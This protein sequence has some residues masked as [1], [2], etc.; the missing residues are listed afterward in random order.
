MLT[1]PKKRFN[2]TL[3]QSLLYLLR[4]D[5]IDTLGKL[6]DEAKYVQNGGEEGELEE[7]GRELKEKCELY[8]KKM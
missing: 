7:I 3:A 4:N 2:F 1:P 6:T 8:R 5:I